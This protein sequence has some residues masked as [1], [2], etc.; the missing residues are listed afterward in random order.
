MAL[1]SMTGFAESSGGHGGA[2]KAAAAAA[3]NKGQELFKKL[4]APAKDQAT[5]ATANHF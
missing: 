4:S 3:P 2:A 5:T 1:S